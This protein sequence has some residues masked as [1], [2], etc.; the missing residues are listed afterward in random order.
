L[1]KKKY[2]FII[3]LYSITLTIISLFKGLVAWDPGKGGRRLPPRLAAMRLP[4]RRLRR[5]QMKPLL[6]LKGRS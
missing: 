3:L 5:R 4:Q 6:A 1:K 2:Y